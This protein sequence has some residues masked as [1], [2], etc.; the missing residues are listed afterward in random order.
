M[1]VAKVLGNDVTVG[2]GGAAGSLLELNVMMPVVAHS[3]LQAITLLANSAKNLAVQA[4]DGLEAT[5]N[6][7]AMVERGLMTCTALAPVIGYDAA[8]AIAKEAFAS[9]R[10][11]R[12]VAR[13]RTDLSEDQLTDLLD[14]AKMTEP[15]LGG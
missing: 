8:A 2:F 6:G 3:L 14:P 5:E 13:D 15:G 4:V 9:G 12:E 10:T 7:P 11:V 1:V